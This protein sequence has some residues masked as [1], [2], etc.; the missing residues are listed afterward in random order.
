M[1]RLSG[2]LLA[3]FLGTLLL[4]LLGDGVVASVV[5]LGKE[6]GW[7][8]ITTGWAL[9]VTLAVYVSG[10][11]SGGHINPA[12]TLAQAVRGEFPWRLVGPYWAAQMAGGFV[13]AAVVYLAYFEAFRAF[14]VA[15]HI[16]RGQMEDGRLAGPAAGGAAIFATFPASSNLALNVFSEF[17]GTLVLV[18]AIA[19]LTDTRNQ[20]PGANLTPALVGVVVWSIGLSLGGLTGYAINPARDFGPRLASALFGWGTA[21]FRSHDF[22]FLVPLLAPLAGGVAGGLLY[23]VAIRRFLP[24]SSE[25]SA[26]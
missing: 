25:G 13:G 2:V 3:E 19:A 10:R 26:I 20:P 17:L 21:V 6:G 7:M 5:L 15:Q 16:T 23:D 1:N 8:V 14:E 11:V 18:L 24:G 4:V 9:A 22:Y 12:F